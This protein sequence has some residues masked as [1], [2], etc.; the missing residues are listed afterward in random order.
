MPTLLEKQFVFSTRVARLIHELEELGFGVTLGE[1]YRTPEQARRYA[2]EGK[3]ISDSLH[4]DRLAIDL[5]LF[6][7]RSFLTRTE[8]YKLA[9]EI[10]ESYS[11]P[12]FTFC[13]GGHFGDGNHFSISHGGRK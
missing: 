4:T 1:A 13:W 10:W 7:D 8:D 3:G 6:R 11:T 12:D 2:S 5:N 9:G